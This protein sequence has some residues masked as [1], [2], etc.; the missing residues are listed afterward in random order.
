M[1]LGAALVADP[2]PLADAEI[3][4]RVGLFAAWVPSTSVTVVAAPSAG[5]PLETLAF[6]RP[7][8]GVADKERGETRPPWLFIGH[9]PLDDGLRRG[10]TLISR[11]YCFSVRRGWLQPT[12]DKMTSL[13]ELPVAE[14]P[15]QDPKQPYEPQ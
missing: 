1:G 6:R 13:V 15:R 9:L 4:I 12:A 10:P 8:M 5:L 7:T 2:R 3:T 14:R 11:E